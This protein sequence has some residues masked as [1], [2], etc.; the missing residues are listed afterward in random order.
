MRS[1][2]I[3]IGQSFPKTIRTIED[4]IS[5]S[6][7]GRN[8]CALRARFRGRFWAPRLNG[9]NWYLIITLQVVCSINSKLRT[10]PTNTEAFLCGLRLCG[11]SKS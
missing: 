8:P 3:L 1:L 11:E 5:P 2:W 4:K 9:L 6:R 7:G 10:V